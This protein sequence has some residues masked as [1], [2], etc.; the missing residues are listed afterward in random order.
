MK[1]IILPFII[2][3]FIV[4]GIYNV[5]KTDKINY[6]ALG[7][8]LAIGENPYKE[9]GYGYADYIKDYLSSKNKLKNYT[10][11]YAKSGDKTYDLIEKIK[12]N[13]KVEINNEQIGIKRA[14][15]ESDLVTISIGANDFMEKVDINN[16]DDIKNI[17]T[18]KKDE[19]L[20]EV[21]NNVED[22]IKEVKKYAKGEIILIGY[23]NPINQ[24]IVDNDEIDDFI[25]ETDH[26]FTKICAKE[27]ITF[28]SIS[29]TFKNNKDYL[30]NPLNIH[31]NYKGY[32]A[33][34]DEVI[35]YLEKNNKKLANK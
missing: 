3:S 32:K 16:I 13:K 12:D 4:Y 29:Q 30:P 6:V 18:S 31:P 7:D 17:D 35:S 10:K 15:R 25:K 21:M 22:T 20:T 19:V 27:D 14:L 24:N 8:S 9:I 28:I 26:L 23:Y 1:K 11:D 34:S 33:I 2:I 5:Y